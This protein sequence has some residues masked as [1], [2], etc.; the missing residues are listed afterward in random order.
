MTEKEAI[1]IQEQAGTLVVEVEKAILGKRSSIEMIVAGLL[2]DGHVLI[3]DVPGVGKTT[4]AKAIAR[5][6]GCS[7]KRIQ[8]TPD[9]LPADVTGVTVYNQKTGEFIFTQGPVFANVV[10]ADEINRA[11]PKTQSSLL[12]CMEESQVT[13][14]G[15]THRLPGPFFVI[16]TENPVEYRGTYP[17]PES[18]LDRFLM[19]VKLGYPSR[20]QEVAILDSQMLSHPLDSVEPVLSE[21][22]LLRLQQSVRH[23]HVEPCVKD[24]IVAIVER[25]RD[26]PEVVLGSSP[27]GSLGLL[28]A[29]QA[30]AA[31]AGREFVT[32]DD[33]KAIALPVLA[34][35]LISRHIPVERPELSARITPRE[36]V[37]AEILGAVPV[38]AGVR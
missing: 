1:E 5:A 21:Q 7:F 37:I 14:D 13:V 11:T 34:H 20:D 29:G 36:A 17:L 8:F 2:A 10:L 3:E 30:T 26:H 27:R 33:V 35:R 32:P 4:L 9:L 15:M 19:R 22:Q 31:M 18:Q 6:L 38:P 16:A 28:R 24:Y 12:E 25:T 23:V